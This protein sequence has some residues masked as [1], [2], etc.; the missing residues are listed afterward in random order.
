V[1]ND[2]IPGARRLPKVEG[3]PRDVIAAL[4]AVD[5]TDLADAMQW[6]LHMESGIKA[7]WPGMPAFAGPAV[8]VTVPNGSQEVRRIAMDMAGPGDVLVVD[9]R[10]AM[11]YAVL[12]GK[13]A[14]NLKRQGLAGVVIDGVVRDWQEIQGHGLPVFC[15]GFTMAASPKTGPGEVNV[16]VAC[17]G[18]VVQPGDVIVGDANGVIVVPRE[19]A[20]ALVSRLNGG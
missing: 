4:A 5:T 1:P 13:L 10:G 3:P 8:T 18:V 20:A 7:L 2:P 6:S 17:G 9:A 14:G 11:G 12:G 19:G 15:R 16:P